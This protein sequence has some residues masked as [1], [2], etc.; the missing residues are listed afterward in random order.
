MKPPVLLVHP[1]RYKQILESAGGLAHPALPSNIDYSQLVGIEI[2]PSSYVPL[3]T[4]VKQRRSWWA[5]WRPKFIVFEKPI[6]GWWFMEG[7]SVTPA[8][9]LPRSFAVKKEWPESV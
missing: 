7:D 8:M 6:L 1:D 3:T 4:T 2:R 5:V 9:E